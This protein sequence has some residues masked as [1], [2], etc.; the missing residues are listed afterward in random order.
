MGDRADRR[1]TR[2]LKDLKTLLNGNGQVR[3]QGRAAEG[4]RVGG[5]GEFVIC[6]S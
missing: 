4:L 3:A 6:D 1:C 5:E 2:Y